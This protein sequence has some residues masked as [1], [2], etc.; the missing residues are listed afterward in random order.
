MLGMEKHA[1]PI[2]LGSFDLLRGRVICGSLFGGLKSKLDIPILVDH[3][4][5]KVN[6]CTYVITFFKFPT[7]ML[8]CHGIKYFLQIVGAQSG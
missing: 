1:A 4:L 2:S 6:Y 7:S 3:Y 5:K 8:C